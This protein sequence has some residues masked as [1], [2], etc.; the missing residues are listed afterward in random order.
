MTTF[1]ETIDQRKSRRVR[2]V[3]RYSA[4]AQ[5]RAKG[6]FLEAFRQC[7]N[8]TASS[9]YAS[10]DRSTVYSWK[11]SDADFMTAYGQA[12]AQAEDVLA[13]AAY[14]RAVLG[15]TR[16]KPIYKN[17]V[18][19]DKLTVTEYS[20]T[21]LMFLLRARNPGKYGTTAQAPRNDE[22]AVKL[23]KNVDVDLV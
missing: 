14:E 2:R 9:E 15:V 5:R 7:G 19:V 23:Y 4:A 22:A 13:Q 17:G 20:D 12:E 21:L 1:S 11:E 8:V 3:G 18:L 16:E 10:V 6:R